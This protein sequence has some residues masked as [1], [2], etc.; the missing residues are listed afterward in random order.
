MAK[1]A[2]LDGLELDLALRVG[3]TGRRVLAPEAIAGLQEQIDSCLAATRDEL[4][5]IAASP[6]ARAVYRASETGDVPFRLRV[7][8]P[9]AEGAD[10]LVAAA[11]E[12]IGAEL[13]FPLPFARAVYEADFSPAGVDAFRN[14]L[15]RGQVFELDGSRD[16]PLSRDESYE[17]AGRFVVG[18]SDF[19]IAIWNGER[20]QGRGGTGE[21]APYA[22][23]AATPVWWIDEN[24]LRPPKFLRDAI[25]LHA[26]EQAPT[27]EAAFAAL[28]DWIVRGATPPSAGK[29][30]R[31][32]PLGLVA[33][34]ICRRW[35][36]DVAPIADFFAEG[37]PPDRWIWRAYTAMMAIV[38]PPKPGKPA[39]LARA[40]GDAEV[41]WRRLHEAP[42]KLANAYGDRY[43]SSYVW[44]ALLVLVA[45]GAPALFGGAGRA[46]HIGI[47]AFEVVVVVSIAGLVVANQTYRWHERWISYRLLAQL[48]RK[49][50][51]LAVVGRALPGSDVS[52]LT[53]ESEDPSPPRDLWVAWYF[54]A[55]LRAAPFA[56]GAMA[57]AKARAL[58]VG[59]SLIAEQRDYHRNRKDRAVR[60]GKWIQSGSEYFFI[61]AGVIGVAKVVTGYYGLGETVHVMVAIGAI[62]S[63]GAGALVGIRTYA[64]FALLARQS[65]HMLRSL[66][67]SEKEL[68]AAELLI[69]KPLSSRQLSQALGVMTSEM[70]EDIAGW[71]QLF[72]MKPISAG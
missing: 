37:A 49:Q 50:D 47:G 52:D 41:Y 36:L 38:A 34:Q 9:L 55:A 68:Q 13:Y 24:G 48:C 45:L 29:P 46:V 40:V 60:A 72:R 42:D 71:A 14:L 70:M 10:R 51:A 44:I 35:E 19:V 11:G 7:V 16:D 54:L 53:S 32:G 23:E 1:A 33:E 69:A 43:R 15:A 31:E 64:E 58:A 57:E 26:P 30:E 3:V 27:G 20:A 18:V 39:E 62:L 17:A 66:D 22:I 12:K 6:T 8:S 21:I 5:R 4:A 2:G 59:Q 63:A 28:S 61:G 56:V 67:A 65:A 25:D